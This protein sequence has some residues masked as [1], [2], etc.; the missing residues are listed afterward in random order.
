MVTDLKEESKYY[1]TFFEYYNTVENTEWLKKNN[2]ELA[3]AFDIY[4][5]ACLYNIPIAWG[6]RNLPADQQDWVIDE[7]LRILKR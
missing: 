7:I 4:S 2:S 3:K 6:F 1:D 5:N